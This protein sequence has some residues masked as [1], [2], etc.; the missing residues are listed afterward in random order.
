MNRSVTLPLQ[1]VR[2][3]ILIPFQKSGKS[4][5]P[6]T[7]KIDENNQRESGS[8]LASVLAEGALPRLKIKAPKPDNFYACS[9][10]NTTEHLKCQLDDSKPVIRIANT[11]TDLKRKSDALS[12]SLP[13]L[14]LKIP[15][16]QDAHASEMELGGGKMQ[17]NS[18]ADSSL[19]LVVSNGKIIRLVK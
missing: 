19:K 8:P 4:S 13:S 11:G 6:S 3:F 16:T 12:T 5:R 10:K 7:P 14:K 18:S 1:R 2:C 17:L 15:R 9:P